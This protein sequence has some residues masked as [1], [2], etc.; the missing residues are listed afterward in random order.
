MRYRVLRSNGK[1]I[2]EEPFYSKIVD[3]HI[4]GKTTVNFNWQEVTIEGHS[5]VDGVTE[6]RVRVE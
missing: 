3:A 2:Q 6:I 4:K 5:V 1:Q